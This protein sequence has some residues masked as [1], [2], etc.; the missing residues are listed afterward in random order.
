M[1]SYHFSFLSPNT[2][3]K[4]ITFTVSILLFSPLQEIPVWLHRSGPLADATVTKLLRRENRSNL[5]HGNIYIWNTYIV[6]FSP[7]SFLVP[8]TEMTNCISRSVYHSS[9]SPYFRKCYHKLP[10]CLSLKSECL[11]WDLLKSL[12]HPHQYFL[13]ICQSFSTPFWTMLKFQMVIII[14]CFISPA[15]HSPLHDECI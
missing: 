14:S 6:M 10:G 1:S 5:A 7:S 2:T 4:V 12:S 13:K 15:H 8:N 11:Y 3:E 9:S